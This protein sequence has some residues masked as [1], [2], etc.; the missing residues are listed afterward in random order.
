M[1]QQEE[2]MS[3]ES[4]IQEL[5]PK[6]LSQKTKQPGFW[7]EMYQQ[8]RLVYHLMRDPE[9]PFYLKFLPFLALVYLVFPA[10]LLPDI[11]V[12]LGQLDDI[13]VMLIGAKV[14]VELAPPAVVARHMKKIRSQDGFASPEEVA[15]AIVI[16]SEHEVV[17]KKEAE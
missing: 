17:V 4:T 14:F 1:K 12:G 3:L 13:T 2:K 7:R 9:V 5:A 8:A 16:D 6:N 15:D 11:L 10:D